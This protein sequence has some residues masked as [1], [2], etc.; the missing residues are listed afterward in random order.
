MNDCCLLTCSFTVKNVFWILLC[1]N[2]Q[3]KKVQRKMSNQYQS[4]CS[5]TQVGF[6]FTL[7]N[8]LVS[9]SWYH[10]L[11]IFYENCINL[12]TIIV[13]FFRFE[14]LSKLFQTRNFKSIPSEYFREG[15]EQISWHFNSDTI[16]IR[17]W[18][19]SNRIPN[20]LL[21]AQWHMSIV[22]CNNLTLLYGLYKLK[23][24][25]KWNIVT[26]R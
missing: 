15:W 10:I 2:R 12:V 3:P 11:S 13:Y 24:E 16:Q 5:Y 25:Q 26:R 20:K 14:I 4:F 9:K 7:L 8:H 17:L 22:Q 19:H 6:L 21:I 23:K 18:S 1:N